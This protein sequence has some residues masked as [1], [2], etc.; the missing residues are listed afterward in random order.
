MLRTS[1]I[2]AL[3]AIVAFTTV[4]AGIERDA[5]DTSIA[6]GDDFWTYANGAWIK[7][8]PIPA[9]RSSYGVGAILDEETKKRTADLIQAATQNAEPGSD[10]QKVGDYYASFM[11]EAGIEAR[12]ITPLQPMLAKIAAIGD[13]TALA[14][15]LG[16]GLRADIDI[17]N[18]TNLY[19]DNLFGLWVS[20]SF[21]DPTL[22]SPFLFQGGLGMPDREYYLSDADAMNKART[23]YLAYITAILNLA[24]I[25]NAEAKA[26]RIMALE[27]KIAQTHASRSESGDIQK[28]NNPWAR[29]DF[30]ARPPD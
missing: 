7:A 5:M 21:Q 16:R 11:D 22:Y 12:G 17:L 1:V 13:R 3:F 9:D 10:G 24:G 28:G 6:P 8:H 18:A 25:A 15:Y 14:R 26:S 20:P 2:G 4:G 23:N 30:M 27:T 29:D 19:T